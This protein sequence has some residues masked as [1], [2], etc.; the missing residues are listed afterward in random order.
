MKKIFAGMMVVLFTA[1]TVTGCGNNSLADYKKA[2]DKTEQITKGQSF[3][4]FSVTMD[5]NTEGMTP[6]GINE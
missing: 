6:E 4:D 3:G 2:V 5:F 1:L